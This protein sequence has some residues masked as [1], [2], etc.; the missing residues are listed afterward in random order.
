MRLI[1]D[2]VPGRCCEK[3][4][5]LRYRTRPGRNLRTWQPSEREL[6]KQTR[7]LP[8]CPAPKARRLHHRSTQGWSRRRP[9][10]LV[11]Q[12]SDNFVCLR[13]N[14]K[15]LRALT[16][17]LHPPQLHLACCNHAIIGTT[18]WIEKA[19]LR[20][21]SLLASSAS[22]LQPPGSVE[23]AQV[24]LAS[25]ASSVFVSPIMNERARRAAGQNPLP[26]GLGSKV[27]GGCHCE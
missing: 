9:S 20:L 13:Q 25:A 21:T 2:R 24:T 23:A 26:V 6:R 19:V 12:R 1:G 14:H 17:S 15:S 10:L 27:L 4:A 5:D 18:P 22:Q 3:G 16:P 11:T 8:F 7:L